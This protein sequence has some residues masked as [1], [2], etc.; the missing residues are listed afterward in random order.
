MSDW[1]YLVIVELCNLY[2]QVDAQMI[3][4]KIGLEL[5]VGQKALHRLLKLNILH[6]TKRGPKPVKT[7]NY[8]GDRHPSEAIRQFHFQFL[9][10][11]QRALLELSPKERE[12]QSWVFSVPTDKISE[13]H[14][15][16]RRALVAIAHKYSELADQNPNIK[17]SIHG[18]SLQAFPLTR[19]EDTI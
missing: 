15:E 11:A 5:K 9:S 8:F 13:L 7:D 16:L 1:Y 2:D 10:R 6:E 4:K 19:H 18:V 17:K 14:S 3:F 12:S